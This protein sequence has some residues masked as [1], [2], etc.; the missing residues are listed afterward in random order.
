MIGHAPRVRN[1]TMNRIMALLPDAIN[2]NPLYRYVALF[3]LALLVASVFRIVFRSRKIQPNGFR[4]KAIGHEIVLAVINVSLT[5][6]LLGGL[7]KILN[8]FGLIQ[9]H[10]EPTTWWVV[11]LEYALYFV[12]FDTW[13]YWFHRLMHIEPMY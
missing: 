7:S 3:V 9:F 11:A 1:G 13:F 8:Y 10:H 12:L 6:F 4:W 2:A 5:G